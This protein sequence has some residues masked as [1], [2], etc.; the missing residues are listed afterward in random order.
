MISERIAGVAVE[1]LLVAG[2]FLQAQ[3]G[4]SID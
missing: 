3:A 2:T 1:F 4:V